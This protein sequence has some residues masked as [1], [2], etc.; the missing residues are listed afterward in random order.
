MK[1][2]EPVDGYPRSGVVDGEWSTAGAPPDLLSG[3]ALLGAHAHVEDQLHAIVGG[4]ARDA[5]D[6]ASVLFDAFAQHH[7]WRSEV[8]IA[9][10]PQLREL[11]TPTLVVAPGPLTVEVLTTLGDLTVDD[12]RLAGWVSVADGLVDSY[13]EH[14]SRCTAVA[15]APLLRWLPLLAESLRTDRR[16]A[17]VDSSSA[18]DALVARTGHFA[19]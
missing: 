16:L 17:S 4:W 2:P 9:R 13:E 18:I 10:M 14:L 8:L 19:R 3:A 11:P 5:G 15:D 1:R 6:A 12:E 7:A